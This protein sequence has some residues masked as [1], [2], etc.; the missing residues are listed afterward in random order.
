MR[1]I[2]FRGVKDDVEIVYSTT[3]RAVDE[4]TFFLIDGQWCRVHD[5]AQYLGVDKTGKEIYDGDVVGYDYEN[6]L[7]F[8]E[9]EIT[10]NL[11]IVYRDWTGHAVSYVKSVGE[12]IIRR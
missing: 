11:E 12:P 5:V 9:G 10:A 7:G 6:W 3:I 1:Q 8:P 4:A 2:K